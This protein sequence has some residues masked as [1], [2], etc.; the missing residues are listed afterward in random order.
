MT[1]KQKLQAGP[2]SRELSD[3]FLLAMGWR[4]MGF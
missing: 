4:K 2:G 3:E 1:L